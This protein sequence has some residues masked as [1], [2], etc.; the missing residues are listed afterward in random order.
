LL[1][2]YNKLWVFGDSYST[3]DLCVSPKDSFWGL[4]ATHLGTSE[5]INCSWPG[6][7]FDS[8]KH[9]IISMQSQIDFAND[10]L[11]IGVPPL[12]R[13][14]VFDNFKNTR[15]NATCIKTD[16]WRAHKQQINCHT[17]LQVIRGDEAQ[18]MVIY[19]DRAWTET[20]MLST[21]FLLTSWLDSLNANY[22]IVNLSKPV[23][24]NNIWGPSEFVLPYCLAHN[25]CILFDNTY[26]S[27]NLD[28]HKP[29]DFSQ[30]GW[31]GHHGA[32]GNRNFFEKSIKDKLC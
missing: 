32:E 16:S 7:S 10:F 12:E 5:I 25:K 15:Y 8:V 13:L 21:I 20:Q 3:P 26:Y 24:A 11:I 30:H 9:M 6:N 23:D 27:V 19:E 1:K 29:A 17:G 18:K 28:Q 22:L 4:A 31:M 2:D 14:T